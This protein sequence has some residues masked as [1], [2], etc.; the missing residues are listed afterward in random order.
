MDVIE[1]SAI[2]C[3]YFPLKYLILILFIQGNP[4]SIKLVYLNHDYTITI[5]KVLITQNKKEKKSNKYTTN[6]KI[7]YYKFHILYLY[8]EQKIDREVELLK[9]YPMSS[10]L[11]LP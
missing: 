8:L 7:I 10:I 9:K 11:S 5:V 6:N 3:G 4:I 2:S 1:F